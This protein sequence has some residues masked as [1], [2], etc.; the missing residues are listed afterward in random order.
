MWFSFWI[1]C[2]GPPQYQEGMNEGDCGD[3]IDN[4]KDGKIDCED[5][6]CEGELECMGTF[7]PASEPTQEPS[8]EDPLESDS[9]G[10]GF[11]ENQGD[12]ND[13]NADIYPDAPESQQDGI[14]SIVMAK[15]IQMQ[16]VM[17]F[18][19]AMTVM[20]Q[21]LKFYLKIWTKIVMVSW[22]KMIVMTMMRISRYKIKT[23]M[24][25]WQQKI[26]MTMIQTS[27]DLK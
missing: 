19:G 15:T 13:A 18:F 17:D 8:G 25:I 27:W 5:E 12:C 9:D 24:A 7:E 21:T 26:A 20:I 11:S 3:E 4:D 22:Q 16:M 2:G 10:D 14:D 1:A 23:V 6:S